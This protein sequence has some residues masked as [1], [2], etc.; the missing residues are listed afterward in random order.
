MM[1]VWEGEKAE[2]VLVY[3]RQSIRFG[4]ETKIPNNAGES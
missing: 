4:R 3:V 1:A 2:S